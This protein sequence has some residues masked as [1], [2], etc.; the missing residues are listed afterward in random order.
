MAGEGQRF[1]DAGFTNP[2]PLIEVNGLP[3][4][5]R[6]LKCLPK[7]LKN[8]LVVRTDTLDINEFKKNIKNY[9]SNV[10]IIEIN[11]LTEG[12]AIT[13]LLAKN[14]IPDN[15][16]LNIGACDIGVE[17]N[18]NDYKKSLETFD[19][20]IWTYNNNNNVLKHPH[21]Y[22]WVKSNSN[23]EVEYVSCKK[24]IS[25]N[26]LQDHVVSGI[27]T[28]KNSS[29]FFKAIKKMIKQND[30]VNNEFYVDN[31]FNYLDHVA[32]VM[33]LKKYSSWGTPGELEDYLRNV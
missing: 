10:I 25:N 2:K 9:F 15:S 4:I 27:F 3:M 29:L 11:K 19:S 26:L 1:K 28:F 13:C 5:V 14:Y 22:G 18:I 17:F 23:N 21:M 12:Q 32:G 30:R 16:I 8:I 31:V 24:P 7:A 33:K 6:A 20:F